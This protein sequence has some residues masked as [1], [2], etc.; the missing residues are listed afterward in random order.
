ML[1]PRELRDWR[2]IREWSAIWRGPPGFF[3]PGWRNCNCC[4]ATCCDTTNQCST[5]QF[6][7]AFSS[8]SGS[9]TQ[10][11]CTGD[12]HINFAASGGNLTEDGG[13]AA[14]FV[15]AG[16]VCTIPITVPTLN[17]LCISASAVLKVITGKTIG[18]T[19]ICIANVGVMAGR[20]GFPVPAS[21]PYLTNNAANSI[22]CATG[23]S[24]LYGTAN[25]N[26]TDGDCIMLK[27]IDVS[28]GAGTYDLK[29]YVNGTLAD[30]WSGQAYSL[31]AGATIEIGFRDTNGGQWQNF[32]VATS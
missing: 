8:L 13:I 30:T 18:T 7:D 26:F 31:T 32:C 25:T 1:T 16:G 23:S 3:G 14:P 27:L 6:S 22:G 10:T 24:H 28:S 9:Y 21:T 5:L 17:G 2:E 29:S 20:Y 4:G 19:G 15:G 12:T 11:K